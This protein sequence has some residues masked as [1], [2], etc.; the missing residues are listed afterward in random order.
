MK[1]RI[2]E[3]S[4]SKNDRRSER[5]QRDLLEVTKKIQRIPVKDKKVTNGLSFPLNLFPFHISKKPTVPVNFW[6]REFL[7]FFLTFFPS[8]ISVNGKSAKDLFLLF[9]FFFIKK[10]SEYEPRNRKKN[11]NCLNRKTKPRKRSNRKQ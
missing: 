10:L 8:K 2:L 11:R 5:K 9:L 6:H 4:S 7:Y 1:R 3:S